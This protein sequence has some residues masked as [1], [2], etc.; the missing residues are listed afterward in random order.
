MI[1][2]S[3]L[4]DFLDAVIPI[5]CDFIKERVDQGAK[6]YA[7]RVDLGK[8]RCEELSSELTKDR[9]DQGAN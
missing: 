1:K 5:E 7:V 4:I 2:R 6:R 3:I 9:V 8:L